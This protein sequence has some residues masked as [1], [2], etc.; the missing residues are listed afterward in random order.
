MFEPILEEREGVSIGVVASDTARGL[1]DSLP[2]FFK[3]ILSLLRRDIWILYSPYFRIVPFSTTIPKNNDTNTAQSTGVVVDDEVSNTFNAFKLQQ[4]EKLRYYIYKIQDKKTI[5]IDSKGERSKTYEDFC[6]ALPEND[7]RYGLI[8]LDFTEDG[9]PTAKLVLLTW[10][11]D[12]AP[13]RAKMLYSGSKEALKTALPG[14]H[15]HDD[16]R[17]RTRSGTSALR[18]LPQVCVENGSRQR[19]VASSQLWTND[20][21]IGTN[22]MYF[23][24]Y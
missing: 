2:R 7:C 12:T 10:N 16:G 21:G 6:E 13:M 15:P 18:N 23:L 1:D 19:E 3:T 9:R 5:V 22:V 14:G 17:R 11:P 24:F 20:G 8:D 4:G